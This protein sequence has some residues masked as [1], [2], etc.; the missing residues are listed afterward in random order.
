MNIFSNTL[1]FAVGIHVYSQVR[2]AKYNDIINLRKW[3]Q[4]KFMAR[5]H[6]T[7]RAGLSTRAQLLIESAK[8]SN[9]PYDMIR[10]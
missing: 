9:N 10:D 1:F 5:I 8:Q 4:T 3:K 6:T 2:A 7:N